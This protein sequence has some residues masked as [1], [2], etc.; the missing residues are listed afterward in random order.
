MRCDALMRRPVLTASLNEDVAHAATRMRDANV[1]FLPV[2]D[3]DGQA[4]GIL[5]DRDVAVRVCAEGLPGSTHVVSVMSSG[6]VSCAPEDDVSWAA[7]LMSSGRKSRVLVVDELGH[8]IGVISLS[9]LARYDP[10]GAAF[11]VRD[12][13]AREV[14]TGSGDRSGRS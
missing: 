6:V 7:A 9:D 5:T 1:G 2:C 3:A 10:R 8:P 4:V 14:L 12:V 11:A 13:A